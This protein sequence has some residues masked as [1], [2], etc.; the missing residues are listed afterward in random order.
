MVPIKGSGF[1]NHGSGLPLSS[2]CISR[3]PK[4]VHVWRASP[5]RPVLWK[6]MSYSGN[7]L[8]GFV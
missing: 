6:H 2:P 5:T 1:I 7:S 4:G 8:Q 3:M